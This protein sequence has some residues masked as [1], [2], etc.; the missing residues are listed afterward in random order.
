M[1]GLVYG[2]S[3]AKIVQAKAGQVL[4][5]RLPSGAGDHYFCLTG[6]WDQ[7]AITTWVTQ[8]QLDELCKKHNISLY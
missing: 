7:D 2:S 4:G 5:I 1:N 8:S 6:L 3:K